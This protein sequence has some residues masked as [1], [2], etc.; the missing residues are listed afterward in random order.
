MPVCRVFRCEPTRTG[1]RRL[2]G[3]LGKAQLWFSFAAVH[4]AALTQTISRRSRLPMPDSLLGVGSPSSSVDASA[5][6]ESVE[7]SH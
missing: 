4:R 1:L 6:S 3:V 7:L 5:T 2:V